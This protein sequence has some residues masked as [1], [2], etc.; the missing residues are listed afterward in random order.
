MN[1]VGTGGL[2][3]NMSDL[4]KGRKGS[5]GAYA[6]Y[7]PEE[8]CDNLFHL[9]ILAD[10]KRNKGRPDDPERSVANLATEP[11]EEA[12]ARLK[13][14]MDSKP[15]GG[16]AIMPVMPFAFCDPDD[17]GQDTYDNWFWW[18][19]GVR[20]HIEA[21]GKLFT[22]YRDMGGPD[23]D[24]II[25]DYEFGCHGPA[26]CM[27][28]AR[29]R[30]RLGDDEIEKRFQKIIDD[31]RYRTDVRPGLEAMGFKFYTGSDHNEMYSYWHSPGKDDQAEL[32]NYKIGLLYANRR[33]CACL[34]RILEFVKE[35]FYPD[36]WSSNYCAYNI[37]I[38]PSNPA[39]EYFL[40][41]YDMADL[42][43]PKDERT[44]TP[45]GTHNSPHLYVKLAADEA[46]PESSPYPFRVF[47]KTPFNAVLKTLLQAQAV[48]FYSDKSKMMPWVGNYTW[49]YNDRL[50]CN[51]T[52]YYKE[53]ILHLGLLDVGPMLYFNADRAN[54]GWAHDDLLFSRLLHELDEVAGFKDRKSL[55]ADYHDC[56]HRYILSGMSAGGKNVWRITPDIYTPDASLPGGYVTADSFYEGRKS[57]NNSAVMEDSRPKFRIGNQVVRFPEGSFIYRP[58]NM[59]SAYGYWV[60]SPE[61]TKPEEFIDSRYDPPAETDYKYVDGENIEKL[62]KILL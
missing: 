22:C 12:A 32:K 26:I 21:Y 20:K 49:S 58:E 30:V 60:I 28:N 52:D 25:Y 56:R 27:E 51:A 2:N 33:K 39:P 55:C 41:Y 1:I 46:V 23:I 35:N 15:A 37:M 43:K 53:F 31:P 47:R 5:F 48:L 61:G 45:Y 34:N 24:A 9:F 62:K 19:G 8:G 14:F 38:N 16:R 59:S 7:L 42:A 4:V 18:D 36:I 57:A 3:I 44:P 10:S 29:S 11:L 50:P 13:G 54:V 6:W 40:A 17:N